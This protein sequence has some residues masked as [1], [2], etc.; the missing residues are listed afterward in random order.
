MFFV[1]LCNGIEN[2]KQSIFI[3]KQNIK[4][5]TLWSLLFDKAQL[6]ILQF[7]STYIVHVKCA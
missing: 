6:V 5:I 3:L 2:F 7:Y 4:F 1:V